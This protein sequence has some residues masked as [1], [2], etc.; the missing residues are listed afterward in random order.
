MK[1]IVKELRLKHGITQQELADK[2]F[3]S[4]RTIISLE[5]QKYNPS[6]LLAYRISAVFN[7]SIEEVFIFEEDD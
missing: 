2:V 7:L 4:S 3:V 1:N 5:K 6:V